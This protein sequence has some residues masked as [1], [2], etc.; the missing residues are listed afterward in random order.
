MITVRF[1]SRNSDVQIPLSAPEKALEFQ[2]LFLNF[3]RNSG[4]NVMVK[5]ELGDLVTIKEE[6]LGEYQDPT[7]L[8][9][10]TF[11][12]EEIDRAIIETYSKNGARSDG[13]LVSF[14]MLNLRFKK[15]DLDS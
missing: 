9:V 13:T 5:F 15:S 10:I 8:Y 11:V 14:E 4:V 3:M 12:N 2:V 7:Q 6:F 1:L